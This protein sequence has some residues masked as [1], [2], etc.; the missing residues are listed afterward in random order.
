MVSS[1]QPGQILPVVLHKGKR[2]V[3]TIDDAV[4]DFVKQRFVDHVCGHGRHQAVRPEDAVSAI[5][6]AVRDRR[7]EAAVRAADE[8]DGKVRALTALHPEW[9]KKVLTMLKDVPSVKFLKAKHRRHIVIKALV[10]P[11]TDA[12]FGAITELAGEAMEGAEVTF[13]VNPATMM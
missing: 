6:R 9:Q 5:R 2:I 1:K 8:L 10:S 3:F 11:E 12:F 4:A 7:E 13:E